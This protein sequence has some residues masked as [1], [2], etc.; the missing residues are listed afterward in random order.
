MTSMRSELGKIELNN[1]FQS[2]KELNQKILL[3]LAETTQTWG[4]SCDRYEILKIEP[5]REVRQSM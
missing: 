1:V 5:P 4:I 2:R 3:S